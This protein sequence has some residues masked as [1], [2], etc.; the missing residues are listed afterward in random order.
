MEHQ[1]ANAD[2]LKRAAL[3]GDW[4]TFGSAVGGKSAPVAAFTVDATGT[5]LTW[6]AAP[7][8]ANDALT[9]LAR[10]QFFRFTA[11][12]GTTLTAVQKTYLERTVFRVSPTVAPTA[13]VL[14]LDSA[15]K[16]NT[17][18]PTAAV[19][20]FGAVTAANSA[21]LVISSSVASNANIMATFQVE[22]AAMDANV[23]RV[24]KGMVVDTY[25]L[26]FG[27]GDVVTE[28]YGFIGQSMEPRGTSFLGTVLPTSPIG[29]ESANSVRGLV[30][31]Y[32][33]TADNETALVDVSPL[34]T[35]PIYIKSFKLNS[36]NNLRPIEAAGI[37]GSAGASSGTFEV[38]GNIE[39]YFTS[40]DWYQRFLNSQA[41]SLAVP[42]LDPDG[43][44]YVYYLPRF[45]A[46]EAGFNAQGENQDLM[47]SMGFTALV[48]AAG[49]L[50]TGVTMRIYRVGN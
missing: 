20:S 10:G 3:Q 40:L 8:Q 1:Y 30:S 29:N 49:G 13:T 44:G 9:R 27:S 37:F 47:L 34:A 43:N 50:D 46:S 24:H 14:T 28:K 5:I 26:S 18:A 11:P 19:P 2:M 35:I 39:M 15:T 17:A 16:F 23:Y 45:K 33:S 42:I 41:S 31:L 6:T 48:G 25:D 32:A 21:G 12:A 22:V 7:A 4:A 36:K 38:T